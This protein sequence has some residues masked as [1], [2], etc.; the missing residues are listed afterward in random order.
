MFT[1]MILEGDRIRITLGPW[2]VES[3]EPIPS[4]WLTISMLPPDGDEPPKLYINGFAVP[5]SVVARP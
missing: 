4:G 5:Q 1:L 2:E 3:L